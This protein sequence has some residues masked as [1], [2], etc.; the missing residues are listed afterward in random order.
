[1]HPLYLLRVFNAMKEHLDSYTFGATIKTIGMGDVKS[2]STPVPPIKEQVAIASYLE[3]TL[4][5]L[6]ELM[7]EAG[8]AI[9]LLRERRT[10]LIS[11][12]VTG[13]IDVRSIT[14]I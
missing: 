5:D 9:E 3:T 13:Q 4:A 8:L 12:A 10:A 2:L 6:D 7:N 11:A 1:M 14:N